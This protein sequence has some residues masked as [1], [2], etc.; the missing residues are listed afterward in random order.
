MLLSKP[1]KDLKIA[2]LLPTYGRPEYTVKSKEALEQP[3][4]DVYESTGISGLRQSIID[5]FNASRTRYDIIAKIDN[6]CIVPQG[7]MDKLIDIFENTDVD[8]ISPN[9]FPSNAA[10]KYG[11]P[12][13]EEL[14]YRRAKIVG[15]LWCMKT[16]LLKDIIFDHYDVTGIKGAFPLLK[17]I[18]YTKQPK[19]GWT[20]AVTVQDI[21]HWS[22]MHPEH[23]KSI[24]HAEY[25]REVGRDIAWQPQET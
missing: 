4:Y 10:L 6:D 2:V 11:E 20:M 18:V 19:V 12:T 5:F 25:S 1:R 7:W 22:G 16:S 9:V 14:G 15:G 8:I 23:I 17:Q 13:E 21:G 24:E 3:G